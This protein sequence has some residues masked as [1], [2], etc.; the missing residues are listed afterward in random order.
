MAWVVSPSGRKQESLFRNGYASADI[1]AQKWID[2]QIAVIR[3]GTEVDG[4]PEYRIVET[5]KQRNE[6]PKLP[7][8]LT[9]RPGNLA[10]PMGK[11]LAKTGETPSEYIR[12]LIADDLGRKPPRMDGHIK[13]INR[14]NREK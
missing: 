6:T 14:V 9:F 3:E 1:S 11:R 8:K 2:N 13:T 10:K 4:G 7:D 5:H 12:R